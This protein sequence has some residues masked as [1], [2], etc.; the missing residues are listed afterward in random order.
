MSEQP[1]LFIN[2]GSDLN[3]VIKKVNKLITDNKFT[4]AQDLAYHGFLNQAESELLELAD[5]QPNHDV[6]DLLARIK[7]QEGD[8]VKAEV[9]W[10]QALLLLPDCEYCQ[11]AISRIHSIQQIRVT[12][13]KRTA[14]GV[15]TFTGV[16][17]S[18]LLLIGIFGTI[19]NTFTSE[20][21]SIKNELSGITTHL[22]ALSD[23]QE[24][25]GL[26]MSNAL[27]QN[28]ILTTQ[29][30][31]MGTAATLTPIVKKGLP[32]DLIK[33]ISLTEIT[34]EQVDGVL[35]VIPKNGLFVYETLIS[36]E[37]KQLLIQIGNV[38]KP[39]AGSIT[40]EVI[41][42]TDVAEGDQSAL[43]L[44]R[45]GKVINF[46]EEKIPLP[47]TLFVI[48][49]PGSLSA[50]FDNTKTDVRNSNRTVIFIIKPSN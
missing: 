48:R 33:N 46:L 13:K 6:Y 42:F 30:A 15:L 36:D 8:L 44:G 45:A 4:A 20:S 31:E 41:G 25:L 39:F 24:A 14:R 29:I 47:E 3:D 43:E 10:K 34:T 5:T 50:P 2:K 28:Q 40:I 19:N 16:L 35:K 18:W 38:L 12:P 1:G 11:K 49:Q 26:S 7:A 22:G 21:I 37:G 27:V 32:Q 17:V 9:Y 23:K